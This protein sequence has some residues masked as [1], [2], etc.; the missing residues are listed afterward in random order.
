MT[1][2]EEIEQAVVAFKNLSVEDVAALAELNTKI[3]N[4]YGDWGLHKGGEKNADGSIQMPWVESDSLIWEFINFM[5][6]K[7]LLPV[8]EWMNWSEGSDLFISTSATKYDNVSIETALKLI[9][10]ATRKERFADG[11]LA[12][13]FESGGF[14]ILVSRLT[15]LSV[16]HHE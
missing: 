8:F 12:A 16:Q 9:Y 11:T 15:S 1:D 5:N 10:A 6:D 14:P 3:Q 4:H 2:T 7:H 13:A